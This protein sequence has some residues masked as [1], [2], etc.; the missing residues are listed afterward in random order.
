M[1]SYLVFDH[2]VLATALFGLTLS[3]AVL[4]C[5]SSEIGIMFSSIGRKPY[6]RAGRRSLAL[7]CAA[8]GLP[9]LVVTGQ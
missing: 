6:P 8:T 5:V 9:S 1:F 2:T 7:G 3:A 4:S